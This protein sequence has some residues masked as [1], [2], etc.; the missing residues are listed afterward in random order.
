MIRKDVIELIKEKYP[1]LT[2]TEKKVADFLF[3]NK[4]ESQ[5]MTI[6]NMA[7]GADVADATIFRF[8]RTLGFE[9]YNDFKL[10]LAKS[11][12]PALAGD[13]R[14]EVYGKVKPDDS[15]EDMLKKLYHSD[16]ETLAQTMKLLRAEDI[17]LAVDLLQSAKAVYC[18]GQGGS[19]LMAMEAWG[20]FMTASNKFHT[21]QDNHHQAMA[22]S[23][24]EAGDVILFFSYS[25]ATRD[26]IDMLP[27]VH[28][29]GGKVILVTGFPQSEAA[30]Y[31]DVVLQCGSREGPLQMGSV[32]TKMSLL[33]IID[34]L[35]NEF[36]RRD[37][38]T[39]IANGEATT[40]AI[41]KKML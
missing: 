8:C 36:C 12:V 28:G 38:E 2:K 29:V 30:Q 25:G 34:V 19:L 23:L 15:I 24:L 21:I 17:T 4:V 16:V 10:E 27:Q 6:S 9:G 7:A 33:Y 39:T 37:M 1:S 31:A 5:Y 26:L 32:A 41:A 14:Y 18:F 13:D 22:A 40:K 11:T 20:R 3:Q 35:Y